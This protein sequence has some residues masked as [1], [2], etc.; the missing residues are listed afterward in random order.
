[1]L[2]KEAKT[3]YAALEHLRKKYAVKKVQEDFKALDI[4]WN[5]YKVTDSSTDTD[6]VFKTLEE[7]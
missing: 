1:M 7:Q 6:L 2:I 4:E 3:P 5:N